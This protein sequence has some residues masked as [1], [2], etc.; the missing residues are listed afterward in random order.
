MQASAGLQIDFSLPVILHGDSLSSGAIRAMGGLVRRVLLAFF[1]IAF[2][3]STQCEYVQPASAAARL[4]LAFLGTLSSL[5]S[6]S[7][8]GYSILPRSF[9]PSPFD[10]VPVASS[11]LSCTR[12]SAH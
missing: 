3:A 10:L 5:V 9:Y 4:R 7:I 1:F 12:S 2:P 11:I 6:S 8:V